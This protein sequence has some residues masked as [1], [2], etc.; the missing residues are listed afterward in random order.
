MGFF[1]VQ[2]R[3]IAELMGATTAVA[4]VASA[5]VRNERRSMLAI[6]FSGEAS[7]ADWCLSEFINLV[8]LLGL[9][10][11]VC[12]QTAGNFKEKLAWRAAPR[13]QQRLFVVV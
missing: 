12:R 1:P 2:S 8:D 7:P 9:R 5:P 6:W 11:S 3:S 4:A 13:A 10:K